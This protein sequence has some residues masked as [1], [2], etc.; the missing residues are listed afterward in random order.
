MQK[1]RKSI[2]GGGGSLSGA[3]WNFMEVHGVACKY[4]QMQRMFRARVH[5]GATGELHG[6]DL[7]TAS[8]QWETNQRVC[9]G[10]GHD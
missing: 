2:A 6:L 4:M 7:R 5:P 3:V 10:E 1:G 8:R 9:E